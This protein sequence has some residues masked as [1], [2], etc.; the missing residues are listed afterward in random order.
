MKCPHCAIRIHESW[1][2][3]KFYFFRDELEW[4]YRILQCPECH[5]LTFE[6]RCNN[7]FSNPE[8]NGIPLHQWVQIFPVGSNRGPVPPEVPAYIGQDYVEACRVL[9]FSAKASAA[10][11]RRCLQAILHEQGYRGRDLASEIGLLLT[12]HR[13]QPADTNLVAEC[14]RMGA[15]LRRFSWS[16]QQVDHFSRLPSVRGILRIRVV[17]L[18]VALYD[19]PQLNAM[20]QSIRSLAADRGETQYYLEVPAAGLSALGA[21]PAFPL[22]FSPYSRRR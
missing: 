22:E 16:Q 21:R 9:P 18:I 11:S 14:R 20:F 12:S 6:I 2:E 19:A 10:L 3:R 17:G 5:Q 15:Y 13:P 8:E 7:I 1:S 4:Q